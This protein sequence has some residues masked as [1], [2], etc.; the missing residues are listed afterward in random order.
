MKKSTRN[1]ALSLLVLVIFIASS[2]TFAL[3]NAAPPDD[4]EDIWVARVSIVIF[5]DLEFLPPDLGNNADGTKEKLFTTNT[6]NL[7]YKNTDEDVMLKDLFEI[8]GETFNSTCVLDYCNSQNN[9]MR[10]YVNGAESIDYE[11]YRIKDKDNI[12]IDYR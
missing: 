1:Q 12:I 2:L 6:D 11:F 3:L 9:S 10:L 5:E 7:I 4:Q 8:W